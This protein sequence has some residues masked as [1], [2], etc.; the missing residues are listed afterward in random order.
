M[1]WATEYIK[2]LQQG[3]TVTIRPRGHSMAGR[4][5]SGDSCTLEPTTPDDVQVG[6][7]VLCQ[8]DDK[9]LL[10]QVLAIEDGQFLIGATRR[11]VQ[12]WIPG[13]AIF[14][15]CTCV[16]RSERSSKRGRRRPW[17]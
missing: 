14:G 10:H 5:E 8:M 6:D 11:D 1:D 16:E 15:L 12:G 4:I 13:D 3:Q 2:Q 9:H 17:T 7:I